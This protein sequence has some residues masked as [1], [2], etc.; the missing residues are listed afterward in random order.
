MILSH[1]A[2]LGY[3]QLIVSYLLHHVCWGIDLLCINILQCKAP[4][5]ICDLEL[6]RRVEDFF[7][8]R[9]PHFEDCHTYIA[10]KG[11]LNVISR[12]VQH[13]Q[14]LDTELDRN[15]QLNSARPFS[16][17]YDQHDPNV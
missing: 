3:S 13:P 8:R 16:S 4:S 17:T 12:T 5:V 10:I 15:F 6:I 1:P 2:E 7:Q 14:I 9:Q 11:L